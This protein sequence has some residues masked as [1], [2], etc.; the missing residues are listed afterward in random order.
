MQLWPVFREKT[1][2]RPPDQTL[3]MTTGSA[4]PSD[5]PHSRVAWAAGSISILRG[6]TDLS[7]LCLIQVG[8]WGYKTF[9]L[10]GLH[11]GGVERSEQKETSVKSFSD[12]L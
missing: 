3:L 8:P 2:P 10:L 11:Q 12:H 6:T 4:L 9:C 7:L 1:L 5:R